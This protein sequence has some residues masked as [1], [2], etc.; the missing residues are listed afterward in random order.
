MLLQVKEAGRELTNDRVQRGEDLVSDVVLS[1]VVPEVFDWVEFGGVGWERQ[2]VKGGICKAA[3][4]W[5][6]AP[7]N[8]I[9][10]LSLGKQATVC[11]KNKDMVSVSTQGKTGEQRSPSKGLTAAK[12]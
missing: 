9:R 6:P 10:Q 2:Q 7:S 5:Q 3:A 12:P 4:V 8:S 1:Q 11:A